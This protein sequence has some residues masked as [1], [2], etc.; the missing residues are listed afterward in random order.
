MGS[1]RLSKVGWRVN[2]NAI[3]KDGGIR[4]AKTSKHISWVC[5][6]LEVI[7]K[8][9]IEVQFE[10]RDAREI[11]VE[12]ANEHSLI[13]FDPPYLTSTRVSKKGYA[14][15]VDEQFHIDCAKLLRKSK[16]YVV[17]SGY[18]SELYKELYE[19]HEWQRHDREA[20]TNM[21]SK[22]VE[23]VWISPRTSKALEIPRNRSLF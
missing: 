13:Y 6:N 17:V 23:S 5:E 18:A 22:R 16:G 20:V 1:G 19:L 15:E 14:F 11:I 8:R 10:C 21:A 2:K 9:L 7:A 12:Y 3:C 4:W